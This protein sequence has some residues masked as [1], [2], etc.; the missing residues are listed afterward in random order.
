MFAV[1][2]TS[3]QYLQEA[4]NQIAIKAG[5]PASEI[6]VALA[7]ENDP[8]SQD[9]RAG[10]L[11][12]VNRHGMTVVI[13]DK[14]PRDLSDMT[15]TLV[16]VK[17]L[18]PDLLVVSGHSKGAALSVR[19]MKD[20][21]VSVNM[22]AMTHCES[23]KLHD[24]EKFGNLADY[25]LCAAQWSPSVSSEGTVFGTAANYSAIFNKEYGYVPPYQAAE[26]TAAVI[27]M[28]DAITRANSLDKDAV[29]DTLAAT[30]LSTFYG[31]IKFSEAGNNIAKPMIL[32][33]LI[34]GKYYVVA[35][36][37]VAE[38]ELVYPRP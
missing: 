19:Q 22:L 10:V 17:A 14:L 4:V 26:S 5:K 37:N 18:K 35:P 23:A 6:T 30:D 27:V 20:L 16:K 11:D 33:Q 8:F 32:R 3:E 7:I 21:G 1:L 31:Q 34:D 12:D 15:S 38:A 2:S 25:A 36:A 24:K 9:I 29:R 13:D 28:A